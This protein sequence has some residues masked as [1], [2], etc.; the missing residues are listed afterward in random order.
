MIIFFIFFILGLGLST[1]YLGARA[2]QLTDLH[3]PSSLASTDFHFSID[4]SRLNSPRPGSIRASVSRKRALSSSP[5]SDS[6]DINSMI[7]FSPNSLP[8][9]VNGSR[10]SS[11]SGSYGHLSA[12][13]LSP[14][15]GVHGGAG[16]MGTAHLQQLQAHILRAG[17]L[18]N[19]ALNGSVH[20]GSPTSS[21]FALAHHPSIRASAAAAAAAAACV[22]IGSSGGHSLPKPSSVRYIVMCIHKISICIYN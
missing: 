8:T 18:F 4:G 15:L 14:S 17:G 16:G 11:A 12:G 5:Y 22:G 13:T 6:F 20:H 7:R 19:P 21:M 9:I 10:S 2:A 1:D 3:P